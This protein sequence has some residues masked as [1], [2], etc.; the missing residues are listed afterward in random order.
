MAAFTSIL[1]I[2]GGALQLGQSYSKSLDEKAYGDYQRQQYDFNSK[3]AGIAAEDA[4][5]RGERQ[6]SA[7][8]AQGRQIQGAQRAA[9]AA[10]GIQVD[11]GSAGM[12]QEDSRAAVERDILTTRNN[13]WREAWGYQSQ[14]LSLAFQG[15]Q[16]QLGSRND[17]SN[18][19][20]T[21]AF[22]AANSAANAYAG[23]NAYRNSILNGAR[24]GL[25]V[26][27]S[28]NYNTDS[29][30]YVTDYRRRGQL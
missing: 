5:A 27:R 3:L 1:A 25:T 21:G 15:Q 26:P 11:S 23:S 29:G 13:A 9:L 18:T 6:I 30:N 14:S 24:T 7:L 17:A 28:P 22:G 12:I 10:Q 16:A 19:L 4:T 2:A 20:L 8:R